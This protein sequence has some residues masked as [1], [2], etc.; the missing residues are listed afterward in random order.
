MLASRVLGSVAQSLDMDVKVSEV[1]GMSQRGGSVITYVRFDKTVHSPLVT[2]GNADVVLAFESLEALRGADYVKPGGTLIVNTHQIDPMPVITGA[3]QYPQDIIEKLS[4]RDLNLIAVDGFDLAKR[5]GNV[6]A[7]N[8]VM[9]G[10]YAKTSG[11]AREVW[12]NALRACV[13]EKFLQINLDA[14]DLGYNHQ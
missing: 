7:V 14:F 9:I 1:H 5:A 2:D 12:E 11:I 6:K 8:I 13:P 3:A 10:V 4:V